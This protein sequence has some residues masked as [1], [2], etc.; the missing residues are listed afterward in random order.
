MSSAPSKGRLVVLERPECLHL[1][2]QQGVGRVSGGVHGRPVIFP[3]NY[4]VFDDAILFRIRSGGDLERATRDTEVAFEIDGV[5]QIY[6]EGWSVLVTGKC[7][8][9]SDPGRLDQLRSV[10][11]LP[12]AGEG[13]NLLARISLDSVS[14]RRLRHDAG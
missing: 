4:A 8:H 6:H 7:I 13:R 1:L 3:V 10:P 14:G 12:W 11:L 2:E 5:D 9:V